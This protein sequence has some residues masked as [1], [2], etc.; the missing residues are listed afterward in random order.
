MAKIRLDALLEELFGTRDMVT[1]EEVLALIKKLRE[2][3]EEEIDFSK[4]EGK[5][6]E[7]EGEED[8]TEK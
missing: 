8:K 1:R 3:G 5:A 2:R 4:L 6:K 7:S